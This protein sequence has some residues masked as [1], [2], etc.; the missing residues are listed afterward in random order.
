MAVLDHCLLDLSLGKSNPSKPTR[1]RFVF[2]AM[3]V[4]DERCRE[5]IE[6]V[7]ES[8]HDCTNDS[9]VDQ[10]KRCQSQLKWWN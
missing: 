10:I 3:W 6:S 5:V 4:R 2:E 1:R 8:F 9:I 7:W